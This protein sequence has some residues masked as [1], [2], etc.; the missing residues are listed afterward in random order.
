MITVL[1]ELINHISICQNDN[2]I[3]D[4]EYV[5][6]KA[7]ELLAKEKEQ[8]KNAF[9]QGYRDGEIDGQFSENDSD[10]SN[11]EN[12]ETYYNDEFKNI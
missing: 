8:I 11:F 7:I 3:S 2:F 9:N 5:K 6:E 1:Q 12:A 10:V 4:V